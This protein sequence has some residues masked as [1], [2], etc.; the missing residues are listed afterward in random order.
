[1]GNCNR[2]R[3]LIT[4]MT[5][6][7]PSKK[8]YE[9][10]CTAGITET[11]QWVRLYPI[12]YRYQPKGR[13]FQKY[14]WIEV[15]L[16]QHGA[17]NDT[18]V[19]SRRPH[20]ETL[21]FIGDPISPK[22]GW[23]ERRRF[24]DSMPTN[25]L[26]ELKSAYDNEKISLGIIKPSKILDIDIIEDDDDWD[27]AKKAI[28]DQ[29][30][31]FEKPLKPLRKIPYKFYYIFECLDSSEPHHSLIIDWELGNL[32]LKES[33]RLGSDKAAAESVKNKFLYE[34]CHPDRDT[35]F[36]MGTNF[37]W[38]NWMVLGVFWPPK[39]YQPELF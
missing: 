30:L 8:Y 19:E 24:I 25:T 7:N 32:F 5:Y 4:V 21:S 17:G 23:K 13:R 28:Y 31:L 36:F 26:M 34:M 3:I 39:Q 12:D 38:N 35:S 29:I 15:D 11:G 2:S 27:E 1:M 20:L 16:E 14:Q 10:V 37:P 22:N 6:P 18:R 33:E 9:T